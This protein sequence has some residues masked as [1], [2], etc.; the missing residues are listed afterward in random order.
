[1]LP[2]DLALQIETVIIWCLPEEFSF[3]K[4]RAMQTTFDKIPSLK[5]P[6]ANFIDLH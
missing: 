4:R 2:A 1:M 3:L 5:P 6:F